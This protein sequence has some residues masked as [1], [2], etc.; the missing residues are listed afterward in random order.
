MLGTLMFCSKVIMEILPNIHLLGALVIVY[1]VVYRSKALIPIYVYVFLNG[2][3]AGFADWWI[4]YLYIWTILWGMTMLIPR[5]LPKKVLCILY[6]FVCCL[7]GLL[8]GVFYAP[9]QAI[10]HGFNLDMTLAWIASGFVFD[11]LHVIGNFFAGLL[12]IPLS[13]TLRKLSKRIL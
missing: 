10:I 6:S 1:T 7:H 4:P 2:L 8:F 5:K 3:Y 12:I 13:D 11:I 9:V